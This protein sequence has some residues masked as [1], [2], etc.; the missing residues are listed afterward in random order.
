MSSNRMPSNEMRQIDYSGHGHEDDYYNSNMGNHRTPSP[1]APLNHVYQLEDGPYH[2]NSPGGNLQIPLGPPRVHTPSD[3]LVPQ[4]TVRSSQPRRSRKMLT[5]PK[6]SVE[7]LDNSYGHNELYE[8]S[9]PV[10]PETH[11]EV[12]LVN[13][14]H[15]ITWLRMAWRGAICIL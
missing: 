14:M 2:S 15:V 9:H 5:V 1:G 3:N 7:G 4:P 13:E 8:Q 6:Y 11:G 10:E 12:S